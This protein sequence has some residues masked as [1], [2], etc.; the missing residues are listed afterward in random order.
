M[1]DHSLSKIDATIS[2]KILSTQFKLAI[3][4]NNCAIEYECLGKVQQ[5][6]T[7]FMDSVI[8]SERIYGVEDPKT[9][10]FRNRYQDLKIKAEGVRP[11]FVNRELLNVGNK[12][13]TF[14]K[15]SM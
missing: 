7:H 8:I 12:T 2:E 9:Q 11:A 3:A 14:S 10:L 4:F 13:Q 15:Q 6:L 5:A 1:Q